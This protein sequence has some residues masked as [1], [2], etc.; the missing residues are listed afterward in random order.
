MNEKTYPIRIVAQT[1]VG[2]VESDAQN[3]SAEDL[4]NFVTLFRSLQK[5]SNL[6]LPVNGNQVF[7]NPNFIVTATIVFLGERPE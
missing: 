3:A 1:T 2:T 5:L 4:A 6:K 7:I